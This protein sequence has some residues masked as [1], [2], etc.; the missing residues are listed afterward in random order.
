MKPAV[1]CVILRDDKI[2]GVSRKDNEKD[3][4]LPGGKVD[5]GESLEVACLRELK[6]ETGL[7]GSIIA[8]VYIGSCEGE[9]KTTCFLVTVTGE[10]ETMEGEGQPKWLTP[11]E[12]LAGSSFR[13]YNTVVLQR[14]KLIKEQKM[15]DVKFIYIRKSGT[16]TPVGCV[17]YQDQEN[18]RFV[19][20]YSA[21][22][23]NDLN[24]SYDKALARK[25]ATRRLEFA[26]SGVE[27][28]NPYSGFVEVGDG[29]INTKVATVL[30]CIEKHQRVSCLVYEGVTALRAHLL[31]RNKTAA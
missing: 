20:G 29:N 12:L 15:K 5:T 17:A 14:L 1:C 8:E 22:H 16:R 23:T 2:L 31:T 10:P 3:F 19:F 7:V 27:R 25:I 30:M 18:G 4:G 26:M 11:E 6:E 13:A 24:K 21:L 9:Y 28:D